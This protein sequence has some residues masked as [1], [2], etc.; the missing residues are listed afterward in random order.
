M[1]AAKMMGRWRS[2]APL[3]LTP[4]NDDAGLAKDPGRNNDFAYNDDDPDGRKTPLGSHIR[5]V[6][7]RDGLEETLTDIRL[8]RVLRRGFSYGPELPEDTFNDDGV[9]R[10]IML[11]I[12]NADPG[13]QFEFVQAQWINDGDFVSQ[14]ERTDPIAGRRN[15]ADDFQFPAKPVRR[16]IAGLPDFTTVKG[17]EHVFLPGIA[18][19][20]WL[21]RDRRGLTLNSHQ[22]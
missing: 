11:A 22:S 18:G 21:T 1:L 12:I 9:D 10:G 20:K 19:L 3:A 16:R 5:R 7:P 17:G 2:G 8:H 14:G 6:N 15:H 4:N 13:R